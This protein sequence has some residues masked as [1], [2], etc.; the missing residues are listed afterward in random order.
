LF[1][2]SLFEISHPSLE[3]VHRWT[4]DEPK[5]KVIISLTLSPNDPFLVFLDF[6]GAGRCFSLVADAVIAQFS[7]RVNRVHFALAAFDRH[8]EH[9]IVASRAI[10]PEALRVYTVDP[11]NQVKT[12]SG[13]R[14][15]MAQLIAHPRDCVIYARYKS[16]LYSWETST[17]FRMRNSVPDAGLKRRNWYFEESE[18]YFDHPVVGEGGSSDKTQTKLSL[19]LLKP[20][21]TELFPDDKYCPDQLLV[22][23]WRPTRGKSAA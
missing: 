4:F 12:F 16:G 22:L 2:K 15:Q 1:E 19:D 8:S 6:A 7:D 3:I 5:M 23:P 17:R 13:P 18:D 21:V 9:V 20:V 11:G 14:E 10:T